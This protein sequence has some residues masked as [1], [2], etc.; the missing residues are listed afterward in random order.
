MHSSA[1][2]IGVENPFARRF[3]WETLDQQLNV[4]PDKHLTIGDVADRQLNPWLNWLG[5]V[6]G[7]GLARRTSGSGVG[8][9]CNFADA[10]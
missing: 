4:Y 7:A 5:R 1:T 2:F 10:M 3:L 6:V 9:C 8:M